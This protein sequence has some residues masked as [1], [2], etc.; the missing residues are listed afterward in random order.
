MTI[1]ITDLSG[2]AHI[3]PPRKKTISQK[4]LLRFS[5]SPRI[6]A[7]LKKII[8]DCAFVKNARKMLSLLTFNRAYPQCESYRRPY[9]SNFCFAIMMIK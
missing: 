8:G 2:S 9:D 3:P 6:T 7:F 1:K 5:G 4:P